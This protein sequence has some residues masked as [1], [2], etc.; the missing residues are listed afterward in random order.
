MWQY[1]LYS[2]IHLPDAPFSLDLKTSLSVHDLQPVCGVVPL[3]PLTTL[4]F[5]FEP[6]LSI[7]VASRGSCNTSRISS[8]LHS[9]HSHVELSFDPSVHSWQWVMWVQEAASWLPPCCTFNQSECWFCPHCSG[10]MSYHIVT[11]LC[12][13]LISKT[14]ATPLLAQTPWKI[15]KCSNPDFYAREA[16]FFTLCP[17]FS[18]THSHWISGFGE[19]ARV[20]L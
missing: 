13:W 8:Q 7:N 20:W 3:C 9:C 5:H 12:Y 4:P 6:L 14:I 19:V 17:G 15:P 10:N 1:V 2:Q 18:I 16:S 11:H